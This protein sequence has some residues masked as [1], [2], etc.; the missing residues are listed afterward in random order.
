MP[1]ILDKYI[2]QDWIRPDGDP[3]AIVEKALTNM[4]F[5]TAVEYHR[6]PTEFITA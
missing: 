6:S 1:V 5:E 2:L 3:S 4:V